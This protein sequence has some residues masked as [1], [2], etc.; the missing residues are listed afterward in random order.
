MSIKVNIHVELQHLA[1]G[2]PSVEVNGST[3]GECLNDLVAKYPDMKKALFD[4][5]GDLV[6]YV[7]V[8]VNLESTFPDELA[9]KVKEGDE[10]H[11]TIV[12]VGG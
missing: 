6:T 7:E 4:E 12:N 1:V 3:V 5:K 10:I 8:Y 11:I 9:Y 2:Q